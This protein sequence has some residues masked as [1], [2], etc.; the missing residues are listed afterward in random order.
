[1]ESARHFA[2]TAVVE[3]RSCYKV[4]QYA[5]QGNG[6]HSEAV[7][8]AMR[9]QQPGQFWQEFS[10]LVPERQLASTGWSRIKEGDMVYFECRNQIVL[11]G[12]SKYDP[13]S[14]L[15]PQRLAL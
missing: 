4:V 13:F 14:Y 11:K 9:V 7:R 3:P 10:I 15:D 6:L 5:D 2:Q 8:I 1:M 12:A